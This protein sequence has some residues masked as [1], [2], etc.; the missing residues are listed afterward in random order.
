MA[1]VRVPRLRRMTGNKNWLRAAAGFAVLLTMLF[2]IVG[3]RT[4]LAQ[5]GQFNP[6]PSLP[7]SQSQGNGGSTLEVPAN[8]HQP[9][10]M[11]MLPPPTA[12][13]QGQELTVAPHELRRQAGYEQVTVT[14]TDQHGRYETGLQRDDLNLYVDGVQRP[15]EFFRHDLNT[16][17][18]VGI[19]VDTSGSMQPKIPQAQ[20]AIAEFINQLND[21][22]DVFLFAFSDRPYLLQPFTTNHKLVLSRLQLL[23]AYGETALFDTIIDGL[24]MVHHGRWDKKALLVVTDGM[25][26][27][28]QAEV[29]QVIA[30][31]RRM[32]VLVYSIGIGKENAAPFSLSLGPIPIFGGD[33]YDQ[34]D[35][36]TLRTLSQETGA[37]TFIIKEVGDGQAI[38]E[39]CASISNELREQYTVGFVA[40]NADRTGYRNLRVDAPKH[41]EDSVRVRKGVSVSGSTESASAE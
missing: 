33:A 3:G 12:P 41:P 7:R 29:S 9:G 8:A 37:R 1:R 11:E 34:V 15:I 16:P 22:D 30:Y 14:V 28:S 5:Q 36:A 32:G 35:G 25:D 13:Q 2:S 6:V 24:L 4:A 18:S 17:V 26:N 38:R 20:A 40:P 23:H 27:Q 39:D 31:A 21:R 10:G 19:I